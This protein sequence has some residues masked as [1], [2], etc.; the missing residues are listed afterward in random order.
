MI[1]VQFLYIKTKENIENLIPILFEVLNESLEIDYY[2]NDQNSL[3]IIYSYANLEIKNT[4][5]SLSIDLYLD[6]LVYESLIY[7]DKE[8]L[9]KNYKLFLKINE[10]Y[11]LKYQYY[12]NNLILSENYL[13]VTKDLKSLILSNYYLDKEMKRTIVGFLE[14]DQNISKA[15]KNLYL[16]RNTLSLRLSKFEEVTNFDIKKFIDGFLIYHLVK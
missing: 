12:N 8:S 15:S 9:D 6:I 14:N 13:N 2:S 3:T 1:K 16:H 11:K 10:V 4:L 7:N 5:T